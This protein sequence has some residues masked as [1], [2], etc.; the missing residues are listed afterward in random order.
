MMYY[1]CKK[2]PHREFRACEY[3]NP[4]PYKEEVA[5]ENKQISG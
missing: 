2:E 5:I 1:R 3:I 4:D